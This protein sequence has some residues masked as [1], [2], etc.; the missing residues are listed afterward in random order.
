M[1]EISLSAICISKQKCGNV[2][3]LVRSVHKGVFFFFF[4]FNL[5]L[6]LMITFRLQRDPLDSPRQMQNL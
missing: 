1:F 6:P 5:R 4:F 3:A 2:G